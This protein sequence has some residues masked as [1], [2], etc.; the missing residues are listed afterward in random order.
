MLD[1]PRDLVLP[2]PRPVCGQSPGVRT[3]R[4]VP[5]LPG[6]GVQALSPRS[7]EAAPE[8]R[9]VA[10]AERPSHTD[11]GGTRGSANWAPHAAVGGVGVGCAAQP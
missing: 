1:P 6:R 4:P 11:R 8:N 3:P 2:L 5:G 10:Q 9:A 7:E